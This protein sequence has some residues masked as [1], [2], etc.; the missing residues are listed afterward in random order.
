MINN[1]FEENSK[2]ESRANHPFEVKRKPKKVKVSSSVKR[3]S[4]DIESDY[5]RIVINV[6]TYMNEHMWQIIVVSSIFL[7]E[8]SAPIIFITLFSRKIK[9]L[10]EHIDKR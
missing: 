6:L 10:F 7:G 8:F 5:L 3:Q 1:P 9:S 4:V 2:H